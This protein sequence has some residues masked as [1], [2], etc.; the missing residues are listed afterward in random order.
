MNFYHASISGPGYDLRKILKQTVYSF[1]P[2]E[3]VT[4]VDNHEYVKVFNFEFL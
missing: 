4:F 2:S 1:K 3:A